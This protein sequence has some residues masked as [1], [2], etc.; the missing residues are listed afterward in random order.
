MNYNT[1]EQ[2]EKIKKYFEN[3]ECFHPKYIIRAAIQEINNQMTAKG[4]KPIGSKTDMSG[5]AYRASR[6]MGNITPN[7]LASVETNHVKDI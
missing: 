3:T 5:I 1:P 2:R 6:E 7:Y 4:E